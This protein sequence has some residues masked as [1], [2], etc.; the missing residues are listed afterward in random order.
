MPV[1]ACSTPTRR[2]TATVTEQ[3][4]ASLV[5]S[6]SASDASR[7]GCQYSNQ[8]MLVLQHW[9]TLTAVSVALVRWIVVRGYSHVRLSNVPVTDSTSSSVQ[10]YVVPLCSE[11]VISDSGYMDVDAGSDC[12]TI[13]RWY[14]S[15]YLQLHPHLYRYTSSTA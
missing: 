1:A 15:H 13:G 4:L 8:C 5:A 11:P 2:C 7:Y 3:Q 12:C 6:I 9:H 10:R 14:S